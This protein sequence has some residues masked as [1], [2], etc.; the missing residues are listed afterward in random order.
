MKTSTQ[1]KALVRNMAKAKNVEAEVILRHFM[2]ER[3][4]E[5]ISLSRY[6]THFILKGGMLIAAMIGVDARTTMDMDTAIKRL[7]LTEPEIASIIANVLKVDLA[8]N[9]LFTLKGIEEI[10]E[11][12]DYPGFRVAIEA[13]LD[14][15]RQIFKVD[16]TTG[17]VITPREIE[18]SYRLMFENRS[19]R[20]L[21]YNLETV[22]AEKFETIISRGVTNT[23]M[24]DFYDIHI[25]TASKHTALDARSF[26]DALKQTGQKR[27]TIAQFADAVKI[28]RTIA[29]SSAMSNLWTRYQKSYSYAA[30]VSWDAAISAI[31]KLVDQIEETD[32]S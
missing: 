12:A 28:I 4:L 13:V 16:I 29:E 7:H 10:R 19:I 1:L 6:R 22:L 24:R 11:A 26:T 8:D 3:F 25:L 5:R 18:Y 23:R 15:T 2:L 31:K 20:I 30:D 14:K 17:D 21:A 27:G 9:V 32:V